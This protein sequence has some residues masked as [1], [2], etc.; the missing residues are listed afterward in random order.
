M[1]EKWLKEHITEDGL[2]VEDF[3][4]REIVSFNDLYDDTKPIFFIHL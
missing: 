1:V 2:T 3:E 4:I